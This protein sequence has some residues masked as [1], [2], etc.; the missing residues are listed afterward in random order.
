MAIH[1]VLMK[2]HT[3][4]DSEKL[5]KASAEDWK[6]LTKQVQKMNREKDNEK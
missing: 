1:L 2:M 6:K 5:R 4:G 3:N